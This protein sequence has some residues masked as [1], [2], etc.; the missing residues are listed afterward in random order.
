MTKRRYLKE[1]EESYNS[2]KFS[3]DFL[4]CKILTENEELTKE[5]LEL[6]LGIKIGKVEVRKQEGITP[7]ADGR[8]IR[9]DVY[10]K[11]DENKVFDVEMQTTRKK[12]L[13]KR[14]RYYQGMMDLNLLKRGEDFQELKESYVIF[15][16]MN[17]PFPGYDRYIYTFETICKEESGLFLGD[18][19]CKVFLNANGTKGEASDGLKDF[20]HLL[21]NGYGKSR[22][23]KEIEKEVIEANKNEKWRLEYMTLYMRDME[24][25]EEGREEQKVNAI[26]NALKKGYSITVAADILGCTVEEA[27]KI[28]D[29][30]LAVPVK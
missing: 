4:F 1:A 27:Q 30:H 16:C 6:I 26:M 17:D 13:P 22:L 3:D 15:I 21:K 29:E 20:L 12:N 24:K 25:R 5:L 11:D 8:G 2:L 9:L 23:V 28:A 19:T 18:G 10:A 14:S 7:T